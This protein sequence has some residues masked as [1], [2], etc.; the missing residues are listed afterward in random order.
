[1]SKGTAVMFVFFGSRSGDDVSADFWSFWLFFADQTVG[2]LNVIHM[3]FHFWG[4]NF[5]RQVFAEIGLIIAG[6]HTASF[7][8]QPELSSSFVL[9]MVI[10][11]ESLVEVEHAGREEF[12]PD[13]FY[14]FD[15]E[16]ELAIDGGLVEVGGVE[17]V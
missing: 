5:T 6:I 1:M 17:G 16:F 14:I 2:M 15:V 3:T 4:W 9:E 12:F 8:K 7:E 10:L 13:S 11:F